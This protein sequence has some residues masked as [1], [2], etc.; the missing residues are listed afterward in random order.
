[1]EAG[2]SGEFERQLLAL[3]LVDQRGPATKE[4]GQPSARNRPRLAE[5]A[6]RLPVARR[7][8]LPSALT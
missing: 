4:F 2:I 3:L 6:T 1:M 8:L 7:G 5:S